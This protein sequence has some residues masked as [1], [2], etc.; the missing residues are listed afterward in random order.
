MDHYGSFP[1]SLRLAP[2][3]F[4]SFWDKG[5]CPMCQS[6]CCPSTRMLPDAPSPIGRLVTAGAL[7]SCV[8]CSSQMCAAMPSGCLQKCSKA[9][10]CQQLNSLPFGMRGMYRMLCLSMFIPKTQR[11]DGIRFYAR[12]FAV[13]PMRTWALTSPK[14][15]RPT[16]R[17]AW[18]ASCFCGSRRAR[19]RV[20]SKH[21]QRTKSWIWTPKL[22]VRTSTATFSE[23]LQSCHDSWLAQPIRAILGR[24]AFVKHVWG[25]P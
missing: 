8:H 11:S 6:R 22:E 18:V 3:S 21:W 24:P 15:C 19:S 23:N 9:Q 16:R 17:V 20:G 2:V 10:W 7:S 25:V 5:P 4:A 13:G 12:S 1:H 14:R